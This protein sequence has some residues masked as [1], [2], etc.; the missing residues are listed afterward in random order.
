MILAKNDA[1]S[2]PDSIRAAFARAGE[3]KR[4]VE[5]EGGHYTVYRGKGAD[6]ASR[7]GGGLVHKVSR[8]KPIGVTACMAFVEHSDK[9]RVRNSFEFIDASVPNVLQ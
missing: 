2:P 4:L 5:V 9:G 8:P 6:Q 1:I 3:P 7:C